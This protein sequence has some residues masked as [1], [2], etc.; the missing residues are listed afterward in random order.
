[1][2]RERHFPTARESEAAKAAA[3]TELGGHQIRRFRHV[4]TGEI[5]E[6]LGKPGAIDRFFDNR[7]PFD[8]EEIDAPAGAVEMVEQ[9]WGQA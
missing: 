1:M 3:R 6:F 7:S 9:H 2:N 5:T 4:R 8:F